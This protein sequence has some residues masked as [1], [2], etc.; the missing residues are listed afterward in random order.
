M[1]DD[2]SQPL[3]PNP[4]TRVY[5]IPR[6]GISEVLGLLE[7]LD[8]RSGKEKVYTLAR[9]LNFDFGNLLLVIKAAELL[10]F[11]Y[12]PGTDVVLKALGKKMIE[13]EMNAK[14]RLLLAQ[15]HKLSLFAYIK[16]Q[17]SVQEEKRMS[18]NDFLELLAAALPKESPE[19]VFETVLNWGR[20]AE[21]L[22]YSQDD[23]F[24]YLDQG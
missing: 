5:P 14:K 18:K 24:V 15:L 17:L 10:E 16:E 21:F 11:V 22:G 23:D 2:S 1:S 3:R 20:W 19:Q 9:D 6:A 4:E 7:V 8:D 13:T 12:T